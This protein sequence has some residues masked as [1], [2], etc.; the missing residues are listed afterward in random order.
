[1]PWH[2]VVIAVPNLLAAM[3]L[4]GIIGAERQWRHR[5]AGL[6]TNALVAV[7]AASFVILAPATGSP[8]AAARIAGQIVSGIGFL[9]AGVIL[10]EG[11]NVRGLNTAAT[12]WC[13]A[14]AGTLCGVSEVLLAGLTT[15]AILGVNLGSQPLVNWINRRPGYAFRVESVYAVVIHCHLSAEPAARAAL[16]KPNGS[17]GV[18]VDTV[19]TAK[20]P[21]SAAIELSLRLHMPMR[22]D[23]FV[24][25][26]LEPLAQLPDVLS[27]RWT[28]EA[29]TE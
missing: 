7:G 14:A 2:L 22:D 1:M 8:D 15:A 16:M 28:L 18:T 9:G 3:V 21:H 12:L 24:E 10:R 26:L 5:T 29:T 4:G 19:A 6:K 20:L 27:T 17:G 13:S 11:L 23:A 25:R